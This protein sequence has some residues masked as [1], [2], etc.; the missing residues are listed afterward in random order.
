MDPLNYQP[1]Y[2][3]SLVFRKMGKW[4]ESQDLLH[5]VIGLNPREALFLTNIG[6]SYT[7][8]HKFDSAVIFHDKAIEMVPTWPAPYDNKIIALLS[9]D[10][11]T[12]ESR[13]VLEDAIQKTGDNMIEYKII[14]NIYDR[15]YEDALEITLRSDESDFKF[16]AMRFLY[17][18]RINYLM[19][20]NDISRKYCDS[21]LV[22]IQ[23]DIVNSPDSPELH[24]FSGVANAY[25]GN[26]DIAVS[27][28]EKAVKMSI[29]D[30]MTESDMKINLAQ[31]Y[32]ILRD[33][34]NAASLLAYLLNNPS[35]LSYDLLKLDPLWIPLKSDPKSNS[36]I[37]KK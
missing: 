35:V 5:Q 22:V 31:I 13:T 33:Y 11:N 29:M 37:S 14:L 28:G 1:L 10:G 36:I 23:K 27:E 2:Y 26:R 17:L 25:L 19:E 21:A 16:H 8:I 7:Y 30:K 4:N 15:K 32:T 9:R 24:G 6:L 3:Q 18:A 12:T 20:R 34:D